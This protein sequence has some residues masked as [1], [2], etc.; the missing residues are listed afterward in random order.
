MINPNLTGLKN[1]EDLFSLGHGQLGN[2]P[3]FFGHDQ[4]NDPF[5]LRLDQ[6]NEHS[7]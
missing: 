5:S 3:F 6:G 1:I 4:E 7:L 2:D